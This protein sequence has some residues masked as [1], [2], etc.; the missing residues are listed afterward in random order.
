MDSTHMKMQWSVHKKIFRF[1]LLI[2]I[3][4]LSALSTLVI[5]YTATRDYHSVVIRMSHS[6]RISERIGK[7]NSTSE[8]KWLVKIGIILK[9]VSL[10]LYTFPLSNP[11]WRFLQPFLPDLRSFEVCLKT[12]KVSW[13]LFS[14]KKRV[15]VS[16]CIQIQLGL[17]LSFSKQW[18]TPCRPIFS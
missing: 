10:A 9:T 14:A 17:I 5:S 15:S 7:M 4:P 16:F 3:R 13:K 12:I 1:A 6:P 2:W 18:D 11:S 8:K